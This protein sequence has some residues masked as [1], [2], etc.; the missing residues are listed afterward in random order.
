M[1]L[2]KKR[3]NPY[4][5][6]LSSK[7]YNIY[8][9]SFENE[10]YYLGFHRSRTCIIKVYKYVNQ[11]ELY[12]PEDNIIYNNKVLNFVMEKAKKLLVLK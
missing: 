8:I 12:W 6:Y 9:G 2:S 4:P 1:K 7:D 3:K 5:S 11:L 10:D